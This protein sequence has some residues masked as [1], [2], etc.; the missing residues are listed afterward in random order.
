MGNTCCFRI[1]RVLWILSLSLQFECNIH[2]FCP[3]LIVNRTVTIVGMCFW[4]RPKDLVRISLASSLE[5]CFSVG[6]FKDYRVIYCCT[7]VQQ[8]FSFP[9]KYSLCLHEQVICCNRS[10]P[11]L[12]FRLCHLH[13]QCGKLGL[14]LV[15]SHGLK[16]VPITMLW[17]FLEES[18]L[19]DRG[20]LAAD[21]PRKCNVVLP[22]CFLCVCYAEGDSILIPTSM[23]RPPVSHVVESHF[24]SHV[25][26]VTRCLLPHPYFQNEFGSVHWK[27]LCGVIVDFLFCLQ[28][29][30]C[31]YV[32]RELKLFLLNRFF[33]QRNK[34]THKLNYFLASFPLWLLHPQLTIVSLEHGIPGSGCKKDPK[35]HAVELISCRIAPQLCHSCVKI[36][37]PRTKSHFPLFKSVTAHCPCNPWFILVAG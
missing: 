37:D 27:I 2:L 18:Y 31:E 35:K 32:S 20:S 13:L 22:R 33:S 15:W 5:C 9:W 11:K 36:Q 25:A 29:L 14:D 3:M 6:K 21:L 17:S 10:R 23:P 12:L 4:L 16:F 28:Q 34:T 30:I 7:V 1:S 19:K 26:W 8:F 24:W